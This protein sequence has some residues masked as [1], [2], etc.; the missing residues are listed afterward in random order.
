MDEIKAQ[1]QAGNIGGAWLSAE[2]L[3][4]RN[5]PYIEFLSKYVW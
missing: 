3:E 4:G 1:I 5:I 2:V